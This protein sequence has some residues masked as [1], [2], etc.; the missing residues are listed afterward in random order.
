MAKHLGRPLHPAEVD[1]HRNGVK[2]DNRLEN[3]E[4]HSPQTHKMTHAEETREMKRL[5]A[6]ID[7]LRA[8]LSKC[9]CRTSPNPG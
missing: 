9:L 4:I 3:L 6:E 2:Q 8:E 1:H 7:R 5:R